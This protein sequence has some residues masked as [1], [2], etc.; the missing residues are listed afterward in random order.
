ML[1]RGQAMELHNYYSDERVLSQMAGNTTDVIVNG[2]FN[3]GFFE[4]EYLDETIREE[5]SEG[6]WA[7][8]HAYIKNLLKAEDD[9]KVAEFVEDKSWNCILLIWLK[10]EFPEFSSI[11]LTGVD[12]A[13]E[14]D[15]SPPDYSLSSQWAICH[16]CEGEGKH[17]NPSIDCGGI[18]QSDWDE[19]DY[20]DREAYMS[21]AYDVTCQNCNGSGKVRVYAEAQDGSLLQW[22][23]QAHAD[24]QEARWSDAAER[25]AEL[26]M[27]C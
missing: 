21:G 27:G 12:T 1:T 4:G 11:N 24:A 2:K 26:R 17:V 19:W 9:D 7:K 20:D 3:W 18:S 6:S 22:C 8:T 23:Y 13:S 14:E 25:A 10:C 5:I 15:L 16:V